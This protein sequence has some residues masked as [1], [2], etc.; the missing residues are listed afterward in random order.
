MR[1]VLRVFRTYKDLARAATVVD[2]VEYSHRDNVGMTPDGT[3]VTMR[4]VLTDSDLQKLCGM[5]FNEVLGATHEHE[6]WILL[7]CIL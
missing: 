1:Q 2:W 4:V 6:R 5:R 3:R 7:N